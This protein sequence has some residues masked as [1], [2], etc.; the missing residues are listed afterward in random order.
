[1]TLEVSPK[2]IM[3]SADH[4]FTIYRTSTDIPIDSVLKIGF[5]EDYSIPDGSHI[6]RV[7]SNEPTIPCTSAENFLTIEMFSGGSSSAGVLAILVQ[8]I[9]NPPS[10]KRTMGFTVEI[11][12]KDG[13]GIDKLNFDLSIQPTMG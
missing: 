1:M 5:P 10:T 2:R 6:C 9:T 7:N 4:S 8:G 3:E 12:D 11:L 13:V